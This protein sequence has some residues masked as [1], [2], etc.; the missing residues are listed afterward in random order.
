MWLRAAAWAVALAWGASTSLS[1][2]DTVRLASGEDELAVGLYRAPGEGPHPVLVMLHGYP[3]DQ[4]NTD[5]AEAAR[6]AGWTVLLVHYRGS[7]GSSGGFTVDNAQADVRNVLARVKSPAAAASWGIDGARIALAGHSMGGGLALVAAAHDPAVRCVA[8]LAPGNA[9]VQ[10]RMAR[11]D[12]S[13]RQLWIDGL[14]APTRRPAPP[15]R[16]PPG[17]TGAQIVDYLVAHVDDVDLVRAAPLLAGRQV[18]VV[19]ASDDRLAPPVQH[20]QPLLDALHQAGAVGVRSVFL[21]ADHNF[22]DQRERVA[23]LVAGWLQ[24]RCR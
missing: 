14:E 23:G 4:Q 3:G 12:P 7:W 18:L 9:A 19:A 1:G 17:V 13:Y 5:V 10:A 22:T 11:N 21:A 20:V 24:E 2:Q 6:A 16:F 15:I 8:A